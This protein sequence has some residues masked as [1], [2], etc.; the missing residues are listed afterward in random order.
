VSKSSHLSA[1]LINVVGELLEAHMQDRS[2]MLNPTA[3]RIAKECR[4]AV[5]NELGIK[6]SLSH[7]EFMQLLHEYA[8]LTESPVIGE[9][10]SRLLALAGVG[11]VVRNLEPTRE[12][13]IAP[14]K[15]TSFVDLV[16][17][18]ARR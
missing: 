7:P 2:W 13:I 6:L 14:K 3:I 10:Y 9:A 1:R 17:N 4:N 12:Q 11:N 18:M 15:E 16:R 8:E 5:K